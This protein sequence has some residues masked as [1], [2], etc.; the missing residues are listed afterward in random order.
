MNSTNHSILL[1]A[2]GNDILGD[3]AVGL[4]AARQLSELLS[5]RIEIK[6]ASTAGFALL[7]YLS[8]FDRVLILD[9]VVGDKAAA[10]SIRKIS[11]NEFSTQSVL[12]PHFVGLPE[13]VET[14]Q[15][16]E[17]PFPSEIKLL[18]M[19]VEDPFVLR[20]GLTKRV[21]ERLPEFVKQ[22]R[23][24]LEDWIREPASIVREG[25]Q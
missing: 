25:T 13:L 16:L 9:S 22:A 18:G 12:S 3:D 4:L 6:E 20:E 1:L 19:T 17:I 15:S 8:G 5:G 2:L 11:V 14:A 24:I 7:D 21:S 10:G 23:K